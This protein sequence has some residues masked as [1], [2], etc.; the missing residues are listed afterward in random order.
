MIKAIKKGAST[1][2]E[3]TFNSTPII[4]ETED[5]SARERVP[6]NAGFKHAVGTLISKTADFLS[7]KNALEGYTPEERARISSGMATAAINTSEYF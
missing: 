2:M 1:P 6:Q 3:Q 5:S 7:T 4:H